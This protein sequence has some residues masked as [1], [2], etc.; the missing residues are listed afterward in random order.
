MRPRRGPGCGC[1]G[2]GGGGLLVLALLGALAWFVVIQ[3]VREFVAGLNP[4]QTQSQTQGQTTTPDQTA[5]TTPTANAAPL[6]QS[7]VQKFVRIRRDVR[8]ALG[9]SFTGLQSV[10]AEVQAGQTPNLLQVVNVLRQAGSSIGKARTAQDAGLAREKMSAGRYAEV[11]SGVNRALGVP[12]IDFA[13]AAQAIQNGQLPNL[14]STVTAASAREKELVAP[15][16]KELELTAA[17]G[18]LGL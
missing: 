6:T 14:D 2:C 17:V 8:A 12:D 15:F 1:L 10:W 16:R 18:L 3:P 13:Q 9:Q 7:D 4:P 5:G 11:R